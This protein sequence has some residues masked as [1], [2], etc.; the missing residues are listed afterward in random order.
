MHQ[1][2]APWA[3]SVC[4]FLPKRLLVCPCQPSEELSFNVHVAV[5]ERGA[6]QLMPVCR[7]IA[8]VRA[9]R[10]P[11]HVLALDPGRSPT[12]Q[13]F[14]DL[15]AC[16]LRWDSRETVDKGRAAGGVGAE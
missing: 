15:E 14:L 13:G 3:L 5:H 2:A 12:K 1:R 9:G 6:R 16:M 10:P 4:A 11:A 7:R 8:T